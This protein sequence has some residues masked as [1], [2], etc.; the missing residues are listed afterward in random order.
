MPRRACFYAERHCLSQSSRPPITQPHP[1]S[2]WHLPS[3]AVADR[4]CFPPT[5][6][7]AACVEAVADAS[8]SLASAGIRTRRCRAIVAFQ[9][10]IIHQYPRD[11]PGP[12]L[13]GT[14]ALAFAWLML[15]Q[16]VSSFRDSRVSHARS[17]CIRPECRPIRGSCDVAG[18]RNWIRSR[19]SDAGCGPIAG[20][21]DLRRSGHQHLQS[22]FD[23]SLP[24]H[25][26]SFLRFWPC[27]RRI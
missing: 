22:G 24:Q 26:L 19:L 7:T 21:F 10:G 18:T 8:E 9:W 11:Y 27:G 12:E 3:S 14:Y 4:G 13:L 1:R 5:G 16:G 23:P 20:I 6:A 17:R 2:R 15:F 25:C